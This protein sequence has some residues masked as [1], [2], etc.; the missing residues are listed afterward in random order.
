MAAASELA[1]RHP[2]LQVLPVCADY[3]RKVVLPD[4]RGAS[5]TV[6]F[7]PGSTFG[8]FGRAE[9]AGFL[10]RLRK[11]AGDGG[12]LLIGLDLVK[13]EGVLHRAYNDSEGVTAEFNL[14]LL[15]RLN[16]EFDGDF[17]R[18]AFRHR[19][20][21]DGGRD[22]IEMQLVSCRQQTVTLGGEQFAFGEE[23]AIRTEYS[24]KF[25]LDG[26]AKLAR[27]AG[28]DVARV[29]TDPK[30]WFSLQYCVAT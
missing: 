16:R 5:R 24:H 30:R 20:V 7:F 29:W 2:D 25:T 28:F 4:V 14:N 15:T 12:A 11:L 8:N 3:T 9:S 22:R 21:W 6:V 13:D 23:E 26:F 18:S 19:A 27:A 17:E 10:A 1:A